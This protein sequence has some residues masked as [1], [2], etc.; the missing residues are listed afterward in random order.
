MLILIHRTIRIERISLIVIK[1]DV[2]SMGRV[3]SCGRR[4]CTVFVFMFELELLVE[5]FFIE[6]IV[7]HDLEEFFKLFGELSSSVDF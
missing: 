2:S 7:F 1:G 3:I 6:I 4:D 5:I